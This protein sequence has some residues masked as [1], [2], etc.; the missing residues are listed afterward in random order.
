MLRYLRGYL[1]PD[2]SEPGFGDG[3]DA[4]LLPLVPRP[5]RDHGY[6]L[7]VG[8]ALFRDDA[9][10][11]ADAPLSEEALWL[12]GLD[13]ERAW[14]AQ[15]QTADAP[16]VSFPSGG[17]HVLRGPGLYVAMRSGPYGQNGVGGHAHND[18]LS[19]VVHAAGRPLIVDPGTGA[20]TSDPVVRDRFRGTAAHATLIL[21]GVEQSPLLDGRPFA[22]P[23]CARAPKVFV[24]ERGPTA[25]LVGKHHGYA[26][27]GV[28]HRRRVV[29]LR[30]LAVVL[31][32]D[33]LF[34]DNEAAVE[35]RFPV[36]EPARPGVRPSV[37]AQLAALAARLRPPGLDLDRAVELGV[38]PRA[39][40][41]P[42]TGSGLVATVQESWIAPRYGTVLPGPLVSFSGR[43]SLPVTATVAIVVLR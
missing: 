38:P 22:L 30:R 39:V 37:R 27:L 17:V 5:P 8:V 42:V 35:V 23:D 1:A 12:C 34:G 16:S 13:A 4:R 31:V 7:P 3:D 2:G 21:D 19:L 10:R 29:L 20:Y 40:L 28:T 24:E 43:L 9:L 14:Q 11:P 26:R 25:A 41:V 36:A 33:T 32:E 18:Q 15:A 6:L